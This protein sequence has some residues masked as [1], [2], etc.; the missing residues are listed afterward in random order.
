MT[1]LKERE[2]SLIHDA[3]DVFR[4]ANDER[5]MDWFATKVNLSKQQLWG[6]RSVERFKVLELADLMESEL[7]SLKDPSIRSLEVVREAIDCLTK[8]ST[9]VIS[10]TDSTKWVTRYAIGLPDCNV[11]DYWYKEF[12][13]PLGV[14]RGDAMVI[15]PESA[16]KASLIGRI[17][18][19]RISHITHTITVYLESCSDGDTPHDPLSAIC[20]RNGWVHNDVGMYD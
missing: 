14:L 6:H 2:Q 3:V 9:K 1:A 19:V 16:E 10:D 4:C 5:T 11:D 17:Q 13:V 20:E 12:N 15:L 8:R 7:A 18:D